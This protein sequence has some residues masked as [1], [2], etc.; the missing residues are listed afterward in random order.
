MPGPGKTT[1][2]KTKSTTQTK[3]SVFGGEA[4][5]SE[6][7]AANKPAT[8]SE[9]GPADSGNMEE[10]LQRAIREEFAGIEN[11]LANAQTA[12]WDKLEGAVAK[13]SSKAD[14]VVA[15]MNEMQKKLSDCVGRV[16]QTEK[17]IS[18]VEDEHVV[19]GTTVSR[20]EKENK[21]LMD[22]VVDLET[23]SRRN[24]L[25]LVG[26]PEGD[27]GADTCGFLENWI[28]DVLELNTS[29]SPLVIER[30]HRIGPTRKP[31][32]PPRT[33]IM[34]F[35]N[36]K[37]KDMVLRAARSKK[38]ILYKNK[39]VRFYEDVATEVHKQQKKFGGVRQQLWKMGLRSGIVPPAK[40]IV[41]YKEQVHRFST[42]E[43]VQS[44]IKQIQESQ[45]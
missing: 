44:F 20:L 18:N 25:R 16:E 13:F 15:A 3:I 34:C 2:E 22:K 35:L 11:K 33:S 36:Y 8:M 26:V 23:R 39:R 6:A 42:P 19:M 31:E 9:H 14:E 4:S 32:E 7:C 28:T 30:A 41:T 10:R 45:K 40:L 37:Q 24:N 38:D 1:K 21:A 5:A 27:E 43:E 17:R 29:R 12:L